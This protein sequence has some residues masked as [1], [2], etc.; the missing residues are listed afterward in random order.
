MNSHD[1]VQV[2]E[3]FHRAL[4]VPEAERAQLIASATPEVHDAVLGLLRHSGPEAKIARTIQSIAAL[5]TQPAVMMGPYRIV[6]EV[7]SGG[8]GAVYL[9]VR[10]D[11]QV[12]KQVAIKLVRRGLDTEE[13]LNRFRQE[14]QIL[15]NLEHPYIARF[16]D[17]GVASDGRPFLVMEYL[18]GRP[19]D[20]YCRENGL[21]LRARCR[22]FLKV[23][24]AV[25]FAHR[26]LV[27]HRDLKPGNILVAADGS[28][29]LLDF[30]M[31]KLIAETAAGVTSTL[32]NRPMT[33]DYTSPEHFRG[34]SI[35]TATDVYSLGGILFLLLTGRAPHQFSGSSLSELER[36]I[37]HVDPPRPSD[38]SG[39]WQKQLRGDLD[40]IVARAMRK[41]PA[42]RYA[43][44]DLLAADIERYLD[45]RPVLARQGNLEYRARKFVARHR[46]AIAVSGL[47]AVTLIGGATAAAIEA[48][49]A[50]RES[51]RALANQRAADASRQDA[52]RQA[53]DAQQQR[54]LAE[55][56]RRRAELE[57][58]AAEAQRL[59]AE[60]RFEQVRQ[61]AGKFLF[62]FDNAIVNI[63]GT[64]AARK[65]LVETGLKYYDTLVQE[66]RGN[67]GLL[68]E[69]ARGYDRLGDVQGNP[70]NPNLG[71]FPGALATYRKAEAI[72]ATISDPSPEFLRDQIGGQVRIGGWMLTRGDLGEAERVLKTAFEMGRRPGADDDATRRLVMDAYIRYAD[73][74]IRQGVH[75]E[76]VEP[77]TQA[78]AISEKLGKTSRAAPADQTPISLAHN[79]LADVYQRME[80]AP[81]A[82]SHIRAAL[83]IDRP[84]YE[85]NRSSAP[86][87]R[88]LLLESKTYARIFL[89][90]GAEGLDPSEAQSAFEAAAGLADQEAANDARA[91]TDIG[92]TQ[93][94]WGDFL[95]DHGDGEN[96]LLH[97]RRALAAFEKM[98]AATPTAVTGKE[99]LLQAHQ[100]LGAGYLAAGKPAEALEQLKLA[101]DYLAAASKQSPGT[102]R[103][104][105]WGTD[106][107][108]VKARAL[109]RLGRRDEAIVQYGAEIEGL[110]EVIKQDPAS[111]ASWN[112]LRH[113]Y[114]ERASCYADGGQWAEAVRS[115]EG[116]LDSLAGIAARRTLRPDEDRARSES[117][118]RMEAW[119]KRAELN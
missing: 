45:G 96:A 95:V 34:S 6:R 30:G 74:K 16:L 37:C 97:F 25:S 99:A 80:R 31:A 57:S 112:D 77:L 40:A 44:A 86:T 9:A 63:A 49:R 107:N 61:L 14:R 101:D 108:R 81:E 7:G 117:N 51:L 89:I 52:Q 28:P 68:E 2:E 43:S 1:W 119:K 85:S 114:D 15:A 27:V 71:D 33:P 10:D 88:R 115:I 11:D 42:L 47:L 73:V 41:E 5:A 38:S 56:Q 87:L 17:A 67:R 118:E 26:N 55:E 106:I 90:P 113:A 110:R 84:L 58:A 48:R 4:E 69:V 20:V 75:G 76:A 111:I 62:D 93:T 50:N 70:Y 83:A 91:A 29:K 3:F 35:T 54:V 94:A 60:R 104:I 103:W 36:V 19:L 100:R 23:C 46:V 59:I 66:A 18:P 82:L 98:A 79:R 105:G 109:S 24:E 78:L 22:L 72:R 39:A 92:S 64:T 53:A 13:L 12:R 8:M 65:M 102:L 21:D 116:A 32:A